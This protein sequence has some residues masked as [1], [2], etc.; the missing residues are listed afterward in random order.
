[1]KVSDALLATVVEGAAKECRKMSSNANRVIAY[2]CSH[3]DLGMGEK[4]IA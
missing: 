1:M 2:S 4:G 3:S